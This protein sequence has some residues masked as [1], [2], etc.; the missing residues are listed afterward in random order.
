MS[1]TIGFYLNLMIRST[2]GRRSMS[3]VYPQ[4]RYGTI[5]VRPKQDPRGKR[6][7]GRYFWQFDYVGRERHI[8]ITCPNCGKVNDISKHEIDSN[9]KSKRVR[10]SWGWSER[11]CV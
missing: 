4:L 1:D 10:T 7:R 8:Y 11:K 3:T 5:G 9:G 2:T 6:K